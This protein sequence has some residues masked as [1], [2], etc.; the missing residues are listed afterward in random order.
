MFAHTSPPSY[1]FAVICAIMR[2]CEGTADFVP[3][4]RL[5][6]HIIPSTSQ[7]LKLI[8]PIGGRDRVLQ[9]YGTIRIVTR[10]EPN[11]RVANAEI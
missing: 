2:L 1:Q 7:I 4:G 8:H 6:K 3:R 9:W 11:L 10:E 5:R